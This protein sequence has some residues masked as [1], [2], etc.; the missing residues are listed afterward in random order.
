MDKKIFFLSNIPIP[1]NKARASIVPV[2]WSILDSAVEKT[3]THLT[4][5]IT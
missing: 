4:F 1:L 5:A 2:L 3:A